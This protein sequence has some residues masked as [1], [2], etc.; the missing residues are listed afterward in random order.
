M[1]GEGVKTHIVCFGNPLHG[2]DGFGTAVYEQLCSK[3]L[4]AHVSVMDGGTSSLSALALFEECAHAIIVDAINDEGEAGKLSWHEASSFQ[5]ARSCGQMSS[6][7]L[8]VGAILQGLEIIGEDQQ[9]V[10]HID[11][12]TCSVAPLQSFKMS[13]SPVVQEQVMIATQ[14]VLDKLNAGRGLS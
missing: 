9:V 2:D 1:M 4:G 8:G 14:M 5:K 12:L 3:D 11:V 13:L 6:H 10:D 7:G